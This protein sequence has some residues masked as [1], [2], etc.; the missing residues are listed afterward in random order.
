MHIPRTTIRNGKNIAPNLIWHESAIFE[1]KQRQHYTSMRNNSTDN[2]T[3]QQQNQKQ[4][5][6]FDCNIMEKVAQIMRSLS[7][8][9]FRFAVYF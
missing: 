1:W 9:K 5:P 6:Y 7:Y 8:F 3:K 4:C 2:K